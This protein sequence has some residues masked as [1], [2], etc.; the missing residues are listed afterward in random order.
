MKN[1]AIVFPGQGSQSIGML[2]D[3]YQKFNAVRETF[4]EA[5]DILNF[6]IWEIIQNNEIELNQTKFTQPAIL[7]SSI[8]IWRVLK[9]NISSTPLLLAGHSVGEYSALV[10]SQALK[11]EHA[12]SL[13]L[14]R[15]KLMQYSTKNI[16]TAMS[17]ILGL[18]DQVVKECCELANQLGIVE[19][20]NFNAPGQVVVSGEHKAVEEANK[21]AKS[22]GAKRTKILPISIPSHCS[23]MKEI[24]KD[25]EKSISNTKFSRAIIPVIQNYET[26]INDS[27]ESIKNSL[28]KQLYSC[29]NW[30]ETI[31]KIE[32]NKVETIIECG[33]NKILSALH[34]RIS[35]SMKYLNTSTVKDL[36][37]IIDRGES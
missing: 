15:G 31:K 22:K 36:E 27:V 9:K 12:V 6:N 23:L 17:A 2:K 13:V 33:P 4:E 7:T 34:K 10:A 1:I 24:S 18:S 8:A 19:P 25:F 37:V 32:R 20:A 26:K 14:V 16:T 30:T 29:V 21:I 35:Q 5:N 28:V 3:Y 11:F